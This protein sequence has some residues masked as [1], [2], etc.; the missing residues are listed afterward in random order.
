MMKENP[1]LT[2]IITAYK[3]KEFIKEAVSSVLNQTISRD[4]YEIICVVGFKDEN[5]SSFLKN[6]DIRE[7][8]CDGT[9]GECLVTGLKQSNGEIIVFLDDDDLFKK[10]K[11]EN[12]LNA[13]EKTGCV[14]YHNNVDLIDKNSRE[15]LKKVHPYYKQIKN[16]IIW[17][18]PR[19]INK[20]IRQRGDFNMS[21]IAVLKNDLL[22]YY[23]ILL[24]IDGSPETTIFYLLLQNNKPFF[25]DTKKLTLYR[26]HESSF[27]NLKNNLEDFK[28][29]PLRYYP[30]R[31]LC[32]QNILNIKIKRLF[33]YQLLIAKLAAYIVGAK[34]LKPT[35]IEIIKTFYAGLTMPSTYYIKLSIA[36]LI[37]NK[38]P[39]FVEKYI[40]KKLRRKVELLK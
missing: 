25:F 8:Y 24:K 38:F 13:F 11:L 7:F 30:D 37:Y 29:I 20:I 28:K 34:D 19:G 12:V 1:K 26:V 22:K 27:T 35:Y 2:V 21:S 32:Y 3:R 36:A 4:K 16:T 15:I 39:K 33:H 23:D 40:N 17:N 31:L 9:L 10:D 14:Y 6:N 5:F 18:P